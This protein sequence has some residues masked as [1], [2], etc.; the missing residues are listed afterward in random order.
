MN[1]WC[2]CSRFC[3]SDWDQWCPGR[4]ISFFSELGCQNMVRV[5]TVSC[6]GR[7]WWGGLGSVGSVHGAE[8]R[9]GVEL[10]PIISNDFGVGF[11]AVEISGCHKKDFSRE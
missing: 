10:R 9:G 2:A 7:V 4:V 5:G 1:K 6:V 3:L 11:T 8:L